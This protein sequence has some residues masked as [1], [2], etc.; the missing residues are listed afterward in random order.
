MIVSD[1]TGYGDLG[2]YGGGAGR[3]METPKYGYILL[4]IYIYRYINTN[5]I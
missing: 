5:I 3:G 2:V 1:D 4:N